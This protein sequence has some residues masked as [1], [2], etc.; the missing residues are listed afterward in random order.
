MNNPKPTHNLRVMSKVAGSKD[1]GTV[2]VAWKREDGSFYVKLNPCVVL[3][4]DD[5]VQIGL[6]PRDELP[7]EEPPVLGDPR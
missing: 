4:W 7:R 3:R 2:G 6:F 1:Q 5:E